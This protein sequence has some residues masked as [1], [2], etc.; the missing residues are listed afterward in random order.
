MTDLGY[1]PCRFGCGRSRFGGTLCRSDCTAKPLRVHTLPLRVHSQSHRVLSLPL[2]L[3]PLP[4]GWHLFA[5]SGAIPAP[6]GAIPAPSSAVFPVKTACQAALLAGKMAAGAGD[7]ASWSAPVLWSFSR[8]GGV[9]KSAGGPAHSRTLP[10]NS[11]APDGTACS[12]ADDSAAP[13]ETRLALPRT[14]QPQ[15]G[16]VYLCRQL[17]S[18]RRDRVHSCRQF[19]SPKRASFS[20]AENAAGSKKRFCA[21]VP[22]EVVKTAPQTRHLKSKGTCPF[23]S[24]RPPVP[25]TRGYGPHKEERC[26]KKD[27]RHDVSLL[28]VHA[29]AHDLQHKE[30]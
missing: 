16:R 28:M 2:G 22:R 8:V 21:F 3:H 15:T 20:A 7:V 24:T 25:L 10:R 17:G 1:N 23:G 19:G 18:P 27:A 11:A 9:P 5:I 13:D 29:F 14:R 26:Q 30:T 12:P 6:W 4:P